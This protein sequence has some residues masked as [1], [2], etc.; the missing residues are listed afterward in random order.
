MDEQLTGETVTA[1]RPRRR[2][3]PSAGLS[4]GQ[5]P[6]ATLTQLNHL[7]DATALNAKQID[8][9]LR[10]CEQGVKL[11]SLRKYVQRR[12]GAL[13]FHGQPGRPPIRRTDEYVDVIAAPLVLALEA[14]IP[15]AA[16]DLV[17]RRA[18]EIRSGGR[19][20]TPE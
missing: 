4:I 13:G 2:G 17:L 5:L 7:A 12:R 10:L 8:T 16:V 6:Q 14:M 19:E 18:L 1:K 3:R 9:Q 15:G 11:D 20:A